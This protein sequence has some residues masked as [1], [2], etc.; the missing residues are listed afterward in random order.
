MSLIR[1]NDYVT[2]QKSYILFESALNAPESI[3]VYVKNLKNFM[4]F[5]GYENQ[6]NEFLKLPED[7]IQTFLENY[8]LLYR[9]KGLKGRTIRGYL[10]AV[11]LFLDVNKVRYFRK[12]LHLLFPKDDEKAGGNKAFTD[13]DVLEQLGATTSLRNKA[14]IH[15]FASVGG[16]PAVLWDPPLLYKNVYPMPYGCKAVLLYIDSKSEYWAFLTPEAARALEKYRD[17]RIRDGEKITPESPV[18]AIKEDMKRRRINNG[19]HLTSGALYQIFHT[20]LGN[21]TIERVKRGN[22]YDKAVIYG[23]RK[24]FNTILKLDNEINSNIA[25]KLMAHKN[26]LDGVYLAPTK[27]QCFAEFVKAI[28]ALTL[29]KSESLQMK[30]S[31]AEK[32][33]DEEIV[34]LKGEIKAIYKLLERIRN[35]SS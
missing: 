22:R 33:K 11:E 17:E 32:V 3:K 23:F 30:L 16:R 2:L 19:N 13:D 5:A 31:K 7:E 21:T 12:A 35:P 20:I 25:E 4:K 28:P 14:L 6:Y 26:G 9:S 24:R 27:E 8:T 15:F 10:S 18:F 34:E 1:E 29:D